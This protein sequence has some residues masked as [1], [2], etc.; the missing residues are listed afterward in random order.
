MAML[1]HFLVINLRVYTL[2]QRTGLPVEKLSP[3]PSAV[4]F[5]DSTG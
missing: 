4:N 3:F 5:R 1:T 2:N